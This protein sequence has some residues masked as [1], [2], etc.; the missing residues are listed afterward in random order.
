M[1]DISM[2][3]AYSHAKTEENWYEIWDSKQLFKAE[4]EPKEGQGAPFSMTLP[5]PNVTGTLHM[6]H[7]LTF[8]IPDVII[9]RKK[10]Q[11]FNTLWLPGLDHAGI[12]TQMVVEKNLKR[13]TG[14][15]KEDLGREKF[16]EMVWDWKKKSE[17]RIIK[18]VSRLGLSLDWSRLKFTLDP[19]MLKVVTKVF[20]QLYKEGEI[21]QG[22][23]MVNNCPSCKTVL[24]D[25]EVDHK[26]LQGKLTYIKYPLKDDRKKYIVVATTRPETMLGDVAVAVNPDDERYKDFIGKE[27]QLPLTERIIPVIADEDV[28]KE[29]GTGGVKITPAHDPV[30]FNIALKHNLKQIVVID[31]FGQMT[32][33]VPE[34]YRGLDRF[35]CRKLV[36]A[37]LKELDLV[38]KEEDYTHNV[39]HCQRC[40]TVVE[41]IVSK[42][43]FLKTGRISKPAI[44]VVEKGDIT[45]IP[46]KWQKVYF[47]WMY[48][49]QDWCISRQLW[50]GHRIPAFY[51]SA[52]NHLMVEEE[53]PG[54]CPECESAEIVQ[55]PDVLDTWFSSALWPFTTLGWQ[56]KAKDFDCFYPTSVMATGFDIIFFWVARMIMMGLHF[57]KD[58]PFREVLINGL[59]RD[60]KGQKMSKT[61][62]NVIDPLDVIEEY[63]SDALRFTLAVQSVPGVDISLSLSR[64]KGYRSFANKIWNASRYVLMN[65]KGDEDFEIDFTKITDTDKWLLHSLNN[66]VERVNDLMDNYR[67]NEAADLIYHFF[68]HEYCDWYLE[69]SKSDSENLDTRK[70]L[71]YSIFTLMQLLHPFMPYISEEIYQKVKGD[72]PG[73]LLQTSFPAFSSQRVFT[74]AFNGVE[75]LKKVVMETRKT[76]TEN[77]IDPNHRVRIF[78][79]CDSG[80][81]QGVMAR[82]MKY[83]DFLTKSAKT[84]IVTDFSGL[85]KGFKGVCLNWEILLP[86]D[87]DNDRLNE[88]TRLNKEF[89]K[90]DKQIGSLEQKLGNENFVSKAPEHVVSN[91]KKNLQENIVKR[92]KIRKTIDDLS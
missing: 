53:K 92:D 51:C 20:V 64:V 66:A 68:W 62:D 60:E 27:L 77:R 19:E 90:V 58:I 50:W 79:K 48:N 43:W 17:K 80:K 65:L 52:C 14:Q 8:T 34:K 42:Q 88:L 56:D 44:E 67:L 1:S 22:T 15:S 69:F 45:F 36:V 81:E 3:K 18:Q 35:A 28:S 46:E 5:P 33:K 6:G 23:Y 91:F 16:L 21:Y 4:N 29:F 73:F 87:N 76:R 57:G 74:G 72:G 10:M 83:F 39:G 12:A 70:T 13:E 54:T 24:S 59:I 75:A 55:D 11:G 25:L 32:D 7:A 71:K 31:K 47:N 40:E 84:D 78:L 82:N 30:D 61:K 86:F 2:E 38:Q 37:D 49:I 26:E 9:R 89:E 85:P 63:G 41:P